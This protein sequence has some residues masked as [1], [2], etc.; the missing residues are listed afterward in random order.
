V[1]KMAQAD[2]WRGLRIDALAYLNDNAKGTEEDLR[3]LLLNIANNDA[4]TKVRAEAIH[5]LASH[6]KGDDLTA[7]YEKGLS[8]QSYAINAECLEAMTKLNP[9]IALQK[10]KGLEN[11]TGKKLIYAIA[12]LYANHGSDENAPFFTRTKTQ[13][14]GFELLGFASIYGKFLKR[15]TK[16]ETA[17]NGANDLAALAKG[18]NKY[19][20]YGA[21]RVLKTNLV[22]NYE[23]RE[24]K[25]KSAI[26]TATKENKDVTAMNA[27]LKTVT[28]TK[29]KLTEIYNSVK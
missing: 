4:S 22:E 14:N 1:K 17:I 21:L 9:T 18:G 13:F 2:K 5:V 29:N 3:S 15:C 19:V 8:E 20:K 16:P 26:E 27:E 24:S 10:A 11:E 12:D 6:F 25:L 7:L 23:S 28:E